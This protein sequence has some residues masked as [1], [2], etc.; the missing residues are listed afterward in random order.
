M[1][2]V[3]RRI[4]LSVALAPNTGTN[5]PN[6][7]AGTGSN[8]V[9]LKGLRTSVKVYNSG[10]ASGCR[11][12]IKIFGLSRSL[13]NQMSTL[14]LVFNIVPLNT[15]TVTAGDDQA[16]MSTVFSGTIY[17]AYADYSSQPDV[18]FHFVCKSGVGSN[19]APAAPSSF[20]GSTSVV[21]IMQGLARQMN[22]GFQNSGVSANLSSP[23]FSGTAQLQAQKC[24]DAAGIYWGVIGTSLEIWPKGGNRSTP[25]VPTISVAT[26]MI[27]YPSI[28]Q[29]GIIV[30]TIFNPQISRGSLVKVESSVLS[31]I[32]SAQPNVNLPTQWAINKL[33]L[34]LDA[35][36]P[37]GDWMSIVYAYNPGYAKTIQPPP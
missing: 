14:G 21:T 20:T 3:Q 9:T 31:G 13:M 17:Q 36:V 32:A 6:T 24:A 19:V 16:G 25:S 37:K 22:L 33:D 11:A 35:Q 5:Q 27:G 28:T 23:Y 15:L 8:T 4:E 30:K 12:D 7:F 34:S 1:A 18:P 29:Q 10:A 2:L 26:G